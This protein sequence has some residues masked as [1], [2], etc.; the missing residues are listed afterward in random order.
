MLSAPKVHCTLPFCIELY[1]ERELLGFFV[2]EKRYSEP[3]FGCDA[4]L[5]KFW[6]KRI[7]W[8]INT[9]LYLCRHHVVI[10]KFQIK[11]DP[12]TKE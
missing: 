2:L 9:E 6:C 10:A 5:G 7:L 1:S 3:V 4:E 12:P 11:V 8:R